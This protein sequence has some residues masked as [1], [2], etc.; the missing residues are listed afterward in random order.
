MK[1]KTVLRVCWSGAAMCVL[2]LIVLL[3]GCASFDAP[4]PQPIRSKVFIYAELVESFDNP[5]QRGES[6]CMGDFCAIKIL[7][8]HYPFCLK[9]EVRHGFEGDWHPGR[10]TTEDC[11]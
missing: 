9:H 8:K 5:R 10:Q 7:R 4:K 1:L 11:D 3:S 2:A 6:V